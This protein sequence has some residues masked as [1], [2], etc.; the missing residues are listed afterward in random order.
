ML[1]TVRVGKL[2]NSTM[3]TS[4]ID[5]QLEHISNETGIAFLK[6]NRAA[7][8]CVFVRPCDYWIGA[9]YSSALLGV[10]GLTQKQRYAE[11][12]GVLIKEEFRRKGIGTLINAALILKAGNKPI[13][14]YARPIEAHILHELGFIEKQTLKNGT[15]KMERKQLYE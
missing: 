15:V 5:I 9:Y 7:K 8:E 12:G 1:S 3:T 10:G 2:E 14:A 11:I 6:E 4:K 13:V